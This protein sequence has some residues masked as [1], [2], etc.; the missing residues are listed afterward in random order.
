MK[1]H[2]LWVCQARPLPVVI[3]ASAAAFSH[4]HPLPTTD[5]AITSLSI[6]A[7][8]RLSW[9]AATARS[10]QC[11]PLPARPTASPKSSAWALGLALAGRDRKF[12]LGLLH[13]W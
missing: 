11:T 1:L 9:A 13:P 3:I 2:L 8:S 10:V 12:P 5:L 4:S 6:A 7:A